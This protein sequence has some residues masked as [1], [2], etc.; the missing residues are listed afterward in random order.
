MTTPCAHGMPTPASCVDC[1]YEGNV[2]P[3]PPPEVER[4]NQGSFIAK[5]DGQCP[6]CNLPIVHGQWLVRSTHGR[7]FHEHCS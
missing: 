4:I 2:P 6:D 7:Y 5:W 3:A 1:M